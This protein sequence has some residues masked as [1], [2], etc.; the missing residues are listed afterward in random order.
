MRRFAILTL[1]FGFLSFASVGACSAAQPK[2]DPDEKFKELDANSDGKLSLAEFVGKKKG[3]NLTKAE[4]QFKA[5]DK[6]SD[7]F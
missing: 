3:D 4:E 7:G 5:K 6:D 2:K 1:A